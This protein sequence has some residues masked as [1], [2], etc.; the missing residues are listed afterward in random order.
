[1]RISAL[2]QWSYGIGE[3]AV[4]APIAVSVFFLLFFLTE[5]V[6][7]SPGQAGGILLLGRLWDAIN[8][9]LIGLLSDATPDSSQW[10]RRYPWLLICAIP[11]GLACA[12][13]WWVPPLQSTGLLA[14]YG[15][16]SIFVFGLFTAVQIPFTA[17]AAELTQGY[18]ER[19]QIMSFKSAF[20]ILGSIVGLLIAQTIF[21]LVESVRSQYTLLGVVLGGLVIVGL[22]L[23]CLGTLP[24]YRQLKKQRSATQVSLESSVANDE[25]SPDES[26]SRRGILWQMRSLLRNKPFC[27]LIGLYLCS[28]VG[29]QTTAAV[30][31]YFVTGWM[32][33][34]EQHFIQ[35][36]LT[37]QVAS[38]C[39][40]PIWSYL[41]QRSSK[42]HIYLLGAPLAIVGLLGLFFL[43]PDQVLWMYGWGIL[44][45]LGISIFYLVPFALLPDV[46]DVDAAQYPELPS[47]EGLFTSVMVFLQ[48]LALAISLFTVTLLLEWSGWRSG[49]ATPI[50]QPASALFAIRSIMGPL[51]AL[52]IL[53][54]M[55]CSWCYPLTR[56]QHDKIAR[57]RSQQNSNVE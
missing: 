14:Y 15:G 17:L 42:Q 21:S 3:M 2:V 30:L 35:M 39:A 13:Q 12:L 25:S 9:P 33:L 57:R 38:I 56:Q 34:P 47:R 46:I 22:A 16:V 27:W 5:V 19:T 29:I 32:Q 18:D 7:L 23:A 24:Y 41:G 10:G 37:V 8:D 52:V 40:V 20:N 51:P 54:G 45:G 44:L 55:L 53:G 49:V 26:F 43:R 36:A 50:A 31:P 11:L 4:V 28:W 6:G 1:M 48:K